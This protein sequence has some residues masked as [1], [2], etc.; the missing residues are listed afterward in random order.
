MKFLW[1]SEV[2]M[3]KNRFCYT[4]P[5]PRPG[6]CSAAQSSRD[7][8][9]ESASKMYSLYRMDRRLNPMLSWLRRRLIFLGRVSFRTPPEKPKP[10]LA[11]RYKGT[12]NQFVP[13]ENQE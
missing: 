11:S 9:P 4:A 3:L 12:D 1:C 7:S 8:P 5:M 2:R 6:H 13:R 10:F